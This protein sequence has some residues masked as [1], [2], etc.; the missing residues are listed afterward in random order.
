M[1]L[2]IVIM[3]GRLGTDPVI[4][5]GSSEKGDYLYARF[6]LAVPRD[7][8]D[9]DGAKVTDFKNC[10]A[11]GQTA[12]FIQDYY[13]KG[14]LV[15][16]VGSWYTKDYIKDGEKRNYDYLSVH[17]TYPSMLKGYEKPLEENLADTR[18]MDVE[19]MESIAESAY[20]E[21]DI[22]PLPAEYQNIFK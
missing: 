16:V 5:Q 11:T 2:N 19:H 12:K 7:Y 6:R 17:H 9:K 15:V 22:P 21:N 18:K 1:G 4:Y 14:D 10:E 13:H 20:E 8:R 3:Q